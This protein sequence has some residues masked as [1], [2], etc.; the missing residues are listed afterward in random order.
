[1]LH[2][3]SE[4]KPLSLPFICELRRVTSPISIVLC[5]A[6]IIYYTPHI[7][8]VPISDLYK[9]IGH[10][11]DTTIIPLRNGN[12]WKYSLKKSNCAQ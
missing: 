3:L 10:C 12:I 7:I 8:I 1:M 6:S 4:A 11:S 9:N 2:L 5:A